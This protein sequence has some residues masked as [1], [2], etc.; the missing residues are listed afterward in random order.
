MGDRRGFIDDKQMMSLIDE[1]RKE[2]GDVDSL[3]RMLDEDLNGIMTAFHEEFPD[4]KTKDYL[5][6]GFFAL[7]FDATVISHFMDTT[8][9]TVY[10]RKSRL[11]KQIEESSAEHK[12]Q[13]LE[14]MS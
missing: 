13:F 6:F 5:F 4:I 8:V 9:N 2:I 11:K 1:L 12:S 10:I 3:V 7:G 14:L